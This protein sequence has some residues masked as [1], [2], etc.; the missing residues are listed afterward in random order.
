M[1]LASPPLTRGLRRTI[2]FRQNPS[3]HIRRFIMVATPPKRLE[4]PGQN[5]RDHPPILSGAHQSRHPYRYLATLIIKLN[6]FIVHLLC[7]KSG[8]N[9]LSQPLQP[10]R[11]MWLHR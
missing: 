10:Q 6:Y 3:H 8:V 7:T 2:F 11:W 4:L 1:T 9:H 5:P